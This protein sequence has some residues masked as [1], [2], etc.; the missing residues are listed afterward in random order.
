VSKIRK[1]CP[2]WF[3][4]GMG[5]K[6][7]AINLDQQMPQGLNRKEWTFRRTSRR[8]SKEKPNHLRKS[9]GFI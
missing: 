3:V 4:G 6:A 5:Y 1:H 9:L 8:M 7:D 2:A